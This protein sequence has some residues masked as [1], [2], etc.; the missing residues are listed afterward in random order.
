MKSNSFLPLYLPSEERFPGHRYPKYRSYKLWPLSILVLKRTLIGVQ[1]WNCPNFRL[2][3]EPFLCVNPEP[4]IASRSDAGKTY[5]G[6]CGLLIGIIFHFCL[7][8]DIEKWMIPWS[9]KWIRPYSHFCSTQQFLNK[10]AKKRYPSRS[11]PVSGST[12]SFSL[13]VRVTGTENGTINEV[14]EPISVF[15]W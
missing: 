15:W 3:I 6:C 8:S 7:S 9:F 5:L 1:K 10:T 11:W 13:N 14:S 4:M 12:L 2:R